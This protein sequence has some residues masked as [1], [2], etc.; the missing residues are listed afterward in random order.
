MFYCLKEMVPSN[1]MKYWLA[2]LPYIQNILRSNSSYETGYHKVMMS[3]NVL[4]TNSSYETGYHKVMMSFN[5]LFTSSRQ[6]QE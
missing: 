1:I 4:F 6:I 2:F 3:F 5:V